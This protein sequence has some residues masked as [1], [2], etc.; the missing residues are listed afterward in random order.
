MSTLTHSI[1][2]TSPFAIAHHRII[3][4][5]GGDPVDYEFLEVNPAF[6]ELLGLPADEITGR[7]GSEILPGHTL[8]GSGQLHLYGKVV[9]AGTRESFEYQA[10]SRHRWYEVQVWPGHVAGCFTTQHI[11]ITDKKIL[12]KKYGERKKELD[13][14]YEMARTSEKEDTSI[15][16]IC[17]IIADHLPGSFQHP[18][19]T[20]CRLV[21]GESEYRSANFA[22]TEWSLNRS[23]TISSVKA[24]EIIVGYLGERAGNGDKPFLQEEKHLLDVVAD[25]IGQFIRR[26]QTE[27][28]LKE[29]EYLLE[30]A[31]KL[32]RFGGWSVDLAENR[33][34]WSDMVARIHEQ[35][36]GFCPSVEDGISYYAPEWKERINK[37]FEDCATRGIPYDEEMEIITAKGNR[38][39]VLT[40]GEAVKDSRGN[41]VKVQGA[42]Q[43]ITEKKRAEQNLRESEERFRRI[44]EI[45]SLGIA[46]VDPKSGQI[47]LVNKYYEDITGYSVEELLAMKFPEL[48]HPDDRA[49]DWEI[50]QRAARG[51]ITY[52]NEK[53]YIR[54]DG[55][56]VWVRLHVAF[57]RDSQ[58]CPER[59]VAICENITE[60]I[61][62][63]TALK[64]SEENYR[65][66]VENQTDLVVKVD[67]EGRFLYVSPSYCNMF[68]KTEEE[69]LGSTF[70]PLVHEDDQK[71][72]KEAMESLYSPPHEVF[73]EQRAMTKDGWRWLAWNDTAVLDLEG[74]VSEIIGVGRDITKR[75]EAEEQLNLHATA[76]NS[77]ANGIVITDPE[78][79]IQWVNPAWSELTGYSSEEV[80]GQNPR[81]LKSG[82]HD[83]AFYKKMWQKLTK[84]QVWHGEMANRRKDGSLYHEQQTITPMTDSKGKVIHFIGIKQDVTD[85]KQAEE[86]LRQSLVEKT[87]LLQELYHRT[88]NNM[89][90]ISSM[91]MIHAMRTDDEYFSALTQDINN[92]I[93]SMSLVHQKLYESNN[94]S[95]I[96][97][98]EYIRDL[99]SELS[100]S[101]LV[102]PGR[103]DLDL[104]AGSLKL[105]IDTA[106][107]CG[108]VMN[109]L[110]SN[111]FKHAFPDDRG[112]TITI[113]AKRGTDH[114][115]HIRYSDNGIGLPSNFDQDKGG[116]MGW[117]LIRMI[118]GYQLV[119][120]IICKDENGMI[121][122]L[123]FSDNKYSERIKE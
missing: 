25:W 49:S 77:A 55:S 5:N 31:S 33:V 28:R 23:I 74:N 88:K 47:L 70:L 29:S 54:K 63:E 50:F 118:V 34:I 106:I 109:E 46:Q 1:L 45:A 60:R 43:D 104:D 19:A 52:R 72:T 107:P 35:P 86:K 56:I 51:E 16:H 110:I 113:K 8:C 68:G 21:I 116:G 115:I 15:E 11:D 101:Y 112:G 61:K 36:P 27:A 92:R 91:L 42:F 94:L 89:Q 13:F 6:E 123:I 79:N 85:H 66:L 10:K 98:G 96:P 121:C 73:L 37:V 90:V 26:K 99:F 82:V 44:F 83:A 111:S 41:I 20:C 53:R 4:N 12:E 76:L 100:A 103:I 64:Q 14:V 32:V 69:L 122:D 93:K 119:G 105:L 7:K 80:L 24:G 87:T 57:I 38:R 81:I 117:E 39:W 102:R 75:K 95:Y 108:L 17:Q 67:K 84:G 18:E 22:E 78:G 40:T 2:S 3:S 9:T 97:F 30:M 114:N 71:S 48:T 62:T 58:G 59:T 65:M 120:T